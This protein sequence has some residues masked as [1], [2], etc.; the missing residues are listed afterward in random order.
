MEPTKIYSIEIVLTQGLTVEDYKELADDIESAVHQ[1]NYPVELTDEDDVVSM[2]D[3]IVSVN[4][5]EKTLFDATNFEEE[6]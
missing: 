5:V 6:E 3:V 2:E 1:C 4:L